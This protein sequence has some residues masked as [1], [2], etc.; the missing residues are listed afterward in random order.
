MSY[1]IYQF[2]AVFIQ[3][4]IL[5]DGKMK[6]MVGASELL[7]AITNEL[8]DQVIN[9]LGLQAYELTDNDKQELKLT[10]T[11]VVF[12][13]RAGS[14][15]QMVLQNSEKAQAFA[16]LWPVLVSNFAP[17]LRFSAALEEGTDFQ[18]TSKS[19]RDELTRQK[20]QPQSLLPKVPRLQSVSNAQG[21][22]KSPPLTMPKTA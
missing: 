3:D 20:N 13:R 9:E 5:A 4:Y 2:E 22:H 10:D 12:P 14:V 7:E 17:G 8:L 21:K 18:A 6:T 1:C 15:F 16:T 11:Q 19:V